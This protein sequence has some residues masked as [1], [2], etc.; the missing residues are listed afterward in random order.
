[1]SKEDNKDDNYTNKFYHT[2]AFWFSVK[3][4]HA[5]VVFFF[6]SSAALKTTSH[7]LFLQLNPLVPLYVPHFGHGFTPLSVLRP[8]LE[9]KSFKRCAIYLERL[10]AAF[11]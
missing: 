4:L 1:M 6:L 11:A 9:S 5:S 7:D 2:W 3:I 10:T 8:R